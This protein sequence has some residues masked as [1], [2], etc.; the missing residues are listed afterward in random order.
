MAF[1]YAYVLTTGILLA[2]SVILPE[3][4]AQGPAIPLAPADEEYIREH[5]YTKN[6]IG[7]VIPKDGKY[8]KT[9]II[10]VPERINLLYEKQ[11]AATLDLLLKIMDGASAK[12]S[13]TAAAYAVSLTAES[14]AVGAVVFRLFDESKYDKVNE[15]WKMTPRQWWIVKAKTKKDNK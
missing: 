11:P 12:Q 13:A 8:A 10:D 3:V 1:E 9:E 6:R 7:T 5:I 15:V 2:F 4:H 14:P